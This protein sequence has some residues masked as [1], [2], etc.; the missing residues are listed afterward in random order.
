MD[1]MQPSVLIVMKR[2]GDNRLTDSVLEF[3]CCA[4]WRFLRSCLSTMRL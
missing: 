1:T 2:V 3:R 4:G